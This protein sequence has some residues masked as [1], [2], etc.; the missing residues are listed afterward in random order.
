MKTIKIT[1]LII[2]LLFA[3]FFFCSISLH[4]Q[5]TD[6]LR[7]SLSKL[8]MNKIVYVGVNKKVQ[9]EHVKEGKAFY[10]ERV[11]EKNKLL[12]SVYIQNDSLITTYKEAHHSW[13]YYDN[14]KHKNLYDPPGR[15][16]VPLIELK[17]SIAY[18]NKGNWEGASA[19][20]YIEVILIKSKS[21]LNATGEF[22]YRSL[23]FNFN[24][25][26]NRFTEK[27]AKE[28][29]DV[30]AVISLFNFYMLQL[31]NGKLDTFKAK[32]SQQNKNLTIT[33]EQRKLIV[34]SNFAFEEK[35]Y[36]KALELYQKSIQLNEFNYPQGYYNM[37]L[38]ASQLE[39][40]Q[41]AIFNM[42]KYIILS[43]NAEDN[44]KAQDKI[45]EWEFKMDN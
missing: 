41:L 12:D 15:I 44:R 17:L 8:L 9:Y 25:W 29:A 20:G 10:E 21:G 31:Y 2:T 39:D 19:A 43:P 16:S 26:S 4:A 24:A 30:N 6:Q 45:Y 27:N 37:A 1:F 7:D 36:A 22:P 3:T 32:A 35:N 28:L 23:V 33:E 40:Y 42:K 38:I 18:I 13:I 5:V 34:Q 11:I 14:K